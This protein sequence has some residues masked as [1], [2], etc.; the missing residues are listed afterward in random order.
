MVNLKAGFAG[1]NFSKTTQLGARAEHVFLRCAEVE[2]AQAD[3]TAGIFD[4]AHQTASPSELDVAAE[5]LAFKH[6]ILTEQYTTDG[7][8]AGS[9]LV[10]KRQ[11]EKQILHGIE[12][13]SGKPL[14]EARANALEVVERQVTEL[15]YCGGGRSGHKP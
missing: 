1:P 10:A 8:D 7:R 9:V 11:M 4:P 3:Q 12:M 14:L 5:H 6:D 2:K 15:R 13:Q